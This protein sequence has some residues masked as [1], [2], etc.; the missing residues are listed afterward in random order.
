[1]NVQI[2][3]HTNV[4]SGL[5][6]KKSNSILLRSCSLSLFEAQAR[7]P[8]AAVIRIE[9]VMRNDYVIFL[10]EVD[11]KGDF[12]SKKVLKWESFF[13]KQPKIRK[14]GDSALFLFHQTLQMSQTPTQFTC[15][16]V[17]TF[18]PTRNLRLTAQWAG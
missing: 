15:T 7:R 6:N 9:L 10:R 8:T 17:H 11:V 14:E 12:K 13:E 16:Y 1:M 2:H 18:V 3:T 5:L 4:N